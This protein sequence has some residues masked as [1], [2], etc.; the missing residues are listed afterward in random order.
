MG[1]AVPSE[2]VLPVSVHGP[3][4]TE[5]LVPT[6]CVTEGGQERC[7]ALRP[8]EA[9][10]Y[11]G[12][13]RLSPRRVLP[14]RVFVTEGG[15]ERTVYSSIEVLHLDEELHYAFDPEHGQT[16]RRVPFAGTVAENVTRLEAN[17]A[18]HLFWFLGALLVVAMLVRDRGARDEARWWKPAWDG[19]FWAA[20][21]VILTWPAVLA[22]PE[23]MVGRHFDLPGTI[24]A[25]SAVPRLLSGFRDPLTGFPAGVDYGAF[26]SFTLL[27]PGLL[28]GVVDPARLHGG[29]QVVGVAVSGWAATSAARTFGARG[30]SALIAGLT[31][32]ASGLAATALVEGHVYHLLDPWLPLFAAA[33]WRATRPDGTTKDA[34]RAGFW[35]SA[36]LL[37]TGY[38]AAAGGVLAVGL[39]LPAFLQ[40]GVPWRRVGVTVLTV[41]PTVGGVALSVF[42]HAGVETRNLASV[43]QS[44]AT[45]ANLVGVTADMDLLEHGLSAAPLPVA[46]ALAAM[47]PFVLHRSTEWRVWAGTGLLA[48]GLAMGPMVFAGPLSP[49]GPSPL[50]WLWSLPG[51]FVLRFPVRVAWAGVLCLGVLAARVASDLAVGKRVWMLV[52]MLVIDVGVVVGLPWRQSSM[53]RGP[54]P[55][56]A[57]GTG[58]MLELLPVSSHESGDLDAWLAA[59]ACEAQTHHQQPIADDCVTVPVYQNPRFRQS[60][61]VVS[62]LLA[63]RANAVARLLRQQGYSFVVLHAD[64]FSAPTRARL[65]ASLGQFPQEPE[66]IYWAGEQVWV[67]GVPT[68]EGREV[69]DVVAFQGDPAGVLESLEVHLFVPRRAEPPSYLQ[70]RLR[71]A[72][73]EEARTLSARSDESG[74]WQGDSAWVTRWQV[75]EPGPY[76]LSIW[77]PGAPA[78]VWEGTVLPVVADD[79]IELRLARSADGDLEI[80]T[81]GLG[82]SIQSRAFHRGRGVWSLF[83]AFCWLLGLVGVGGV[84]T[85]RRVSS[86]GLRGVVMPVRTD[87]SVPR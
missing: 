28:S 45:L 59:L 1:C 78:P 22:G 8:A 82:P 17:H 42:G 44:S 75:E 50:G 7:L 73:G 24:W 36:A 34:V 70:A 20:M 49:L 19:A 66:I 26:D 51:A 35:L 55:A 65:L 71:S 67:F 63:G 80:E 69:S 68:E 32:A 64:L 53:L 13:L 10:G 87:G 76:S 38:L 74:D 83:G 2:L 39:A 16:L 6:V 37:T 14:L 25:L 27:A 9:G 47:A 60:E 15:V 40:H 18:G 85:Q 11:R 86:R 21:G 29:L 84:L 41:L 62:A 54:I 4:T 56:L 58:P 57:A 77:E 3:A 61:R 48:F 43:H 12:E 52:L 31:F 23:R 72:T 46:L 33:W 5:N 30:G 79:R 81:A